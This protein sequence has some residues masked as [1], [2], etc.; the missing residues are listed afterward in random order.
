MIVSKTLFLYMSEVYWYICPMILINT[1]TEYG[2]VS[3]AF[4]SCGFNFHGWGICG[5][6]QTYRIQIL[7]RPTTC[8]L[9]KS[10]DYYLPEPSLLINFTL[11]V[12]QTCMDYAI[13]VHNCWSGS[14][15]DQYYHLFSYMYTYTVTYLYCYNKCE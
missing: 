12:F 4:F 5:Y 11:R 8:L 15:Y 9:W 7:Y 2:L 3:D 1:F 14:T 13:S 6:P 10:Q